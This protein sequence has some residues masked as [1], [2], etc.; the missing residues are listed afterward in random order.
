MKKWIVYPKKTGD[1]I[2]QLIINRKIKDKDIDDLIKRISNKKVINLEK[3][4][5]QLN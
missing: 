4:L 1:I 3:I 2:N 5:S